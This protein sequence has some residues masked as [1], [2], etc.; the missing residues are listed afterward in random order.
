MSRHLRPHE[1]VPLSAGRYGVGISWDRGRAQVDVDLQAVIVDDRG[2][3]IDAVYYN[4][5]KAVRCVTHSGD[6]Q[7]GDRD[8]LDEVIW[9]NFSRMPPNV[10]MLIFV[11]AAHSGGHLRD[12]ENGYIH[13]LEERKE[14]E[15]A[16][17]AMERSEEEVDLVGAILRSDFASN[18]AAWSLL[19]VDEP[20]QD[21]RHFV[22]ILEPTI[23][24]LIRK[25]IP[26]APRRQ[27]VAF[28]MEKGAVV[29]L[30][31]SRQLRNI[32]AGLGWDVVGAGVDLDVSAVCFDSRKRV[33]ETIFF[34]NLEGCGIK[35]SGDNLTGDGD[36]DDEQI[37]CGLDRI[38][39]HV[40]QVF[41]VVN[42]YTKGVTFQ[43][44]RN[45]Y[46]RIF[47]D[48][49]DE[50]ARYQL[51]EAGRE[52][53]LIIARLFRENVERWG[54]QAIGTF[55]S[56]QMAKDCVPVMQSIFAKAPRELQLRTGTTMAFSDMP[57]P[58]GNVPVARG[59]QECCVLQ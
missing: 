56:G 29:D 34:G 45:A 36:G 4:N 41:F 10:R 44:V 33:V 11:V 30:P 9:I 59:N 52:Q 38:P 16:R 25:Y 15:V 32:T 17:F 8:G 49:G 23:G 31:Q 47:N 58:H 7:T 35:H 54:F 39:A 3:I 19:V 1:Q 21:G 14:N 22:D 53:A 51:Q 50:M 48:A 12:V 43:K 37:V 28:A 5:M 13:V 57:A 40:V 42:V 20:A 24:N 55:G 18:A 26:N 6:E 2:A 46:V 27:K